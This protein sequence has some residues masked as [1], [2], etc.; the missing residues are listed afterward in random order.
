M[1]ISLNWLKQYLNKAVDQQS[2]VELI[3][4]RLVEIES[5]TYLADRYKDA[6]IVKVDQCEEHPDSDHLH[7]CLIDDGGSVTSAARL[8]D[9][10]VQ[11]VCGAPNVH[12]G[13]SAVWLPPAAVVP[14]TYGTNDEFVLGSRKLRGVLSH[15]MLASPKELDLWNDHAGIMEITGEVKPGTK[16][17]DYL[18][19]D[20]YLFEVENKSLTHRPDCFGLVGFAREVAAISN[21][22]AKIPAWF[23]NLEGKL[24]VE[25]LSVKPTVRVLDKSL[26]ARYECV[27]LD[28]VNSTLVLP[29]YLRSLIGR[30]GCNSVSAP[31]DITN[32]LM[33]VSGQPLHA[34]DLDKLMA[35]SPTGNP[36][37][38]IRAAKPGEKL[39]LIDGRTIEL[40]SGDIVVAVGNEL[41]SVV[42]ALAGAMGGAATEITSDTTRVLLES[43]TF[44]LYHLR[45]TQFRHG[46]FSEA[47]TRFTKGQP[48]PLTRPVL[49]E[50]VAMLQAYADAH[51]ISQICQDYIEKAEPISL[52][53][54]VKQVSAILGQYQDGSIAKPYD[55]ALILKTLNNL[56]YGRVQEI[57]GTITAI[58][59]WW[60]TDLHIAEDVI[61]DIGRVNGYDN[62]QPDSPL[63]H[64]MAAPY[65]AT[66]Q[67]QTWLKE[68]FKE[69]GGNE[70]I[71]YSFIHGDLLTAVH[72]DPKQAYRI[73]NAISPDLQYYRRDLLPNLVERARDN[74]R[75]GYGN[76]FLFEFG[77]VHRQG[78]MDSAEPTL[79][80]EFPEVSGIVVD[81]ARRTESA[82]YLAKRILNYA[83]NIEVNKLRYIRL[84]QYRNEQG[85]LDSSTNI[86]EPLRSAAITVQT[87]SDEK[88]VGVVGEF[89]LDVQRR[90]KLPTFTA[91]FSLQINDLLELLDAG[92]R[93]TP[94]LRYQ[95]T[96]RDITYQVGRDVTYGA[97]LDLTNRV[98]KNEGTNGLVID[99]L[100]KDIYDADDFTRNITLHIDFHDE[101]RTIDVKIVNKLMDKLTNI[102]EQE[103][104]AKVI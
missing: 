18:Q 43:A 20:D 35:I 30:I 89:K 25:S 52:A 38:I 97:V 36:D 66:Y 45:G 78:Y 77:K 72:D 94:V 93:Y 29:D 11:V 80:A 32:Y 6:V 51:V 99:V 15:G 10:H 42:I 65:N 13:M 101:A 76:F 53:L 100:A 40:D 31:V 2:L 67:K 96:S 33:F 4:S 69:A 71:T 103:L 83:L 22:T 75:A 28:H 62:I 57:E 1:I 98:L 104:T 70:L 88:L 3:G 17:I 63:R 85:K 102:V 14:E 74:L 5:V 54:P 95:G 79:P 92:A 46:I 48:A 27:A 58:A 41:N 16:L 61:E 56:Q 23:N 59:P 55:K 49:L 68:R 12:T 24:E 9:G 37:I 19:L 44:D 90:F 8:E 47:I 86:F 82:F 21:D 87:G 64:Y 50:A 73:V 91:G 60:R 81:K 7:V 39:T 84:D 26:C 34:F